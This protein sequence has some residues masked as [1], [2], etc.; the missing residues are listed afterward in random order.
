MDTRD[1]S[2]PR[3]HPETDATLA[4][5]RA[6]RRQVKALTS[7]G[8]Y[9]T[10]RHLGDNAPLEYQRG[11]GGTTSVAWPGRRESIRR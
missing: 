6:N 9:D 3:R 5:L 2:G 11:V 8:M 1:C 4:E 10:Y 7:A